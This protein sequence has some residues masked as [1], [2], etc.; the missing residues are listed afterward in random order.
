MLA[1]V[2][3]FLCLLPGSV[4]GAMSGM[5]T[6]APPGGLTNVTVVEKTG[7]TQSNAV[8]SL[9]VP[10]AAGAIDSSHHI[11]AVFDPT[12]SATTLACDEN[13]R[14]SDLTPAVRGTTLSCVIPSLAAHATKQI[15]LSVVSG[16]P[17][18]CVGGCQDIAISD[19][20]AT[21]YANLATIVNKHGTTETADPRTALTSGNTSYVNSSTAAVIGKWRSGGGIVTGYVSY[22]PFKSDG[23]TVD[24]E[25]LYARFDTECYKARTG[26]VTGDNPILQCRTDMLIGNGYAQNSSTATIADTWFGLT[27]TPSGCLPGSTFAASRPSQRLFFTNAAVGLIGN[28]TASSG[29][30]NINYTGAIVDDGTGFAKIPYVVNSTRANFGIYKSFA[31]QPLTGGTYTIYPINHPYG[32]SQVFRCDWVPSGA[33]TSVD[34]ERG[35]LYIGNAW[36]AVGGPASAPVRILSRRT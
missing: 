23:G 3:G 19:I 13:N 27:M 6:P 32:S 24:P 31:N 33:A 14:F 1:R 17:N 7:S 4:F 26:V 8:F 10:F 25:G 21:S 16:A 29:L 20:V 5:A 18:A 34:I 36:N 28:V 9:G 15:A 2:A 30:F 35:S 22:V 12:S 11:Q